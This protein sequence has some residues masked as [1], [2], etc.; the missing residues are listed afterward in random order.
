MQYFTLDGIKV[1]KQPAHNGVLALGPSTV[2]L[3]GTENPAAGRSEAEIPECERVFWLG[4]L[5]STQYLIEIDGEEQTEGETD[6][7]GILSVDFSNRP[8]GG[9]YLRPRPS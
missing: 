3:E 6:V 4:L 5:P 9:M 2:V 7:S 1:L 8:G